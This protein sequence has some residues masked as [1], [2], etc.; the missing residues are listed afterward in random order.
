MGEQ[1]PAFTCALALFPEAGMVHIMRPWCMLMVSRGAHLTQ[2]F[3]EDLGSL[4]HASLDLCGPC[5]SM[6]HLL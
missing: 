6:T 2:A 4:L 1:L 5:H 3:P